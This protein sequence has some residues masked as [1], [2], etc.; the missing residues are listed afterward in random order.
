MNKVGL[1]SLAVMAVVIVSK[2]VRAAVSGT[3]SQQSFHF[4]KLS[5]S[6]V[7]ILLFLWKEPLLETKLN[8]MTISLMHLF[9]LISIGGGEGYSFYGR[10]P[11][12]DTFL[13]VFSGMIMALIG[14]QLVQHDLSLVWTVV[15]AFCFALAL[16]TVWEMYEF[17]ADTFFDLNMQRYK[18][19]VEQAALL[20]TM[21]DIFSNFCGII[22]GIILM[23]FTK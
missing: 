16:G 2:M 13:H 19:F 8:S 11:H 22:V 9:I 15:F 12:F 21:K 7:F 4:V 18:G 1:A 6:V 14:F 3:L 20:D 17:L 23:L 10:F 5:S